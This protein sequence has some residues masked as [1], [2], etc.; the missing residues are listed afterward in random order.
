VSLR[1]D[2]SDYV[3]KRDDVRLSAQYRRIFS[4]MRDGE[5]RYLHQISEAVDAPSPSVSAQLRHMRKRR[6]GK[7]TVNKRYEGAGL[8]AYQLVVNEGAHEDFSSSDC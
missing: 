4:L 6:F 5:W 3:P 7:H 8:Y 2:G 1:F